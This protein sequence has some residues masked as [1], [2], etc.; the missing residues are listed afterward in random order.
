MIVR[1]TFTPES[2]V[3]AR[4]LITAHTVGSVLDDPNKALADTEE[5]Q[6]AFPHCTINLF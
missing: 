4:N 3:T 2:V 6:K 5:A 1:S